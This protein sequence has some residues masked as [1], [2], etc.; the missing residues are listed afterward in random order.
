MRAVVCVLACFS[1]TLHADQMQSHTEGRYENLQNGLAADTFVPTVS[2]RFTSLLLALNPVARVPGNTWVKHAHLKHLDPLASFRY[3]SQPR[4]SRLSSTVAVDRLDN[5]SSSGEEVSENRTLAAQ[6]SPRFM[7][8]A[9][10]SKWAKFDKDQVKRLGVDAFF[11]YGVVSNLNVALTVS[12]AWGISSKANGLSPI[13][14]GQWKNFVKAYAALYVSLGTIL[15]PFRMALAVGMTPVYGNFVTRFRGR[16]P[17]HSTNPQL[18][19]TMALVIIS[20]LI[21]IFG[22]FSLIGL[23]AYIAGLITGVPAFP[24]GWKIG[25]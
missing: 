20:L 24:P 10:F 17:F 11:T 2:R 22:T 16:L 3:L 21:N 9:W 25:A 6:P 18:N 4:Q 12:L 7:S 1:L 19:R 23:G 5:S 14:P 8:K 13:S 15:R